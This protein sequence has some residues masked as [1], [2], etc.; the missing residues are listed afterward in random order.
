[1]KKINSSFAERMKIKGFLII[2]AVL[3]M[4]PVSVLV[5]NGSDDSYHS[6]RILVKFNN[7][8]SSE[9]LKA[10]AQDYQLQL[11]RVIARLQVYRFTIQKGQNVRAVIERVVKTNAWRSRSLT[12][13]DT[14]STC[15]MI[16][17]S[18]SNGI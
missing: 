12:T 6:E 2:A 16:P 13:Y 9:M 17:C 5:S 4:L 11:E 15:P 10:F 3:V 14:P 7:P 8:P 18:H 1:M